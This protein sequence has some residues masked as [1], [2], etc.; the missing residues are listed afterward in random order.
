ME[1]QHP[2]DSRAQTLQPAFD[3]LRHG[4]YL[5]S[6]T[7]A[8]IALLSGIV[9]HHPTV[10]IA[11]LSSAALSLSI[12]HPHR[13]RA[14][15]TAATLLLQADRTWQSKLDVAHLHS[16]AQINALQQ[17]RDTLLGD[18]TT[19]T[20]HLAAAHSQQQ[21]LQQQLTALTATL[22]HFRRDRSRVE[23][24]LVAKLRQARTALE[25][26]QQALVEKQH[27][28]AVHLDAIEGQILDIWHPLYSGLI[29]ICDRFDPS[30]PVTTLE[31]AGKPVTLADHERRQWKHY[32]DSLV[33]YD[34]SLRS[35][36][37]R[38]SDDCDSHD[39]AYGFFL[40]LLEELTVNYCKLWANI[41][42]LE[43]LSI[44]E[45]EKR[46]IYTEFE[47][48]RNDYLSTASGWVE[49][50]TTVEAGFNVIED[51]FKQE[52]ASLQQRI[53]DAEHL[54]DRLQAPRKFRGQTSI[55]KAGNRIIDHFAASSV[56]LDAIESVKIPGG[57][58]LRFKVDRNPDST[59]LTE[60][61]FDKH[62]D[63]LGLWGL[64]QRP[65]DFDLDPRNFLLS[66]ALFTAPDGKLRPATPAHPRA[67]STTGPE[68][69][70]ALHPDHIA[71]RFQDL[72]CYSA[73][74][75]EEVVRL[76][77]VPRV[78]VVAGSTGGKSPLLELIAAA[79]ARIQGGQIWLINP[80]PGSP[81]DWFHIPGVVPPGS[82]GIQCAITWLKR[83][84]DEFKARRNDL[85][86][87]A[88]QPFITVMV[89]EINAIA[90]DYPDLGTVM[91][92]FYQLSDHTRM[93]FLTAGQGGNVSGVSGGSQ[94]TRK[95]GNASKLMEEDF[96]NA[97]Q[98]FTATAAKTWIE[99]HLK[100][101]PMNTALERLTALNQLCA[102]LNSAE[103]KSAYPTDPTRK[104][105]SPDAYR[106]ALVV[107]P[108]DT[109]PFFI[110]LPPYSHYVGQLDGIT[111][112]D[113]AI[114]TAPT[115]NQRALGLLNATPG[116]PT[117]PCTFCGSPGFRRK[118]HYKATGRPR[119]VCVQ[120]GR[121]PSRLD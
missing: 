7:A 6:G 25:Q 51:S 26:S 69:P 15:Q 67:T 71:E 87:T 14:A 29:A 30:R 77:F 8:A 72:H 93:G 20:Q 73:L 112:P 106:I 88:H 96:Q 5:T 34:A 48:F 118:G 47:S 100:G 12:L 40:R 75:F 108:R 84:H 4:V 63:H 113:G 33:L 105:V 70:P 64:S 120:C 50:S 1:P 90:R 80:I 79:I 110:Q 31:Y 28:L 109:D 62:C 54:I 36:I 2:T 101:A 66:V 44:H 41:K 91:K 68:L 97:T 52:L 45:G 81:K 9:F 22:D 59:R 32:R 121:V 43:L 55:D 94:I 46:A 21:H 37:Q 107:S 65:L 53:V 18:R 35:R 83:A 95:T 98:V 114:V 27:S 92:D 11:G 89:D 23:Q 49:K 104:T 61:E 86:G 17:E 119:Y 57:F 38:M 39:D 82:D 10:A 115:E 76:K 13:D 111:Y 78:R 19:L 16:Q 74:E 116:K 103:G 56:I 58:Q 99:K 102:E 85:P 117:T 42:D 60:A 3:Y 24:Q